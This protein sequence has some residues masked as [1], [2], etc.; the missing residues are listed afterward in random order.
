MSVHAPFQVATEKTMFAMPETAI[1]LIPDVGG[2]YFLPRLR[3][4]L[5][6]YLGLTGARLKGED[7]YKAGIASHYV[8]SEHLVELE[9]DLS[10]ELGERK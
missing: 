3:G 5:G 6:M 9:H 8:P 10:R 1:G 7:V 4:S 2:S